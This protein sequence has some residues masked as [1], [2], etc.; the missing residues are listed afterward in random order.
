MGKVI[1]Q[2]SMSLDGFITG[3]NDNVDN[4]M[5]EG[6]E[7]LHD[8]MFDKSTSA[9]QK[10]INEW[11]KNTGAV[12]MGRHSFDVGVGPWDDNPPFHAS[13]FVLS[14]NAQEKLVKKGGTTC[15]F[16][17][18]GIKSALE[19]AKKAAGDKQVILHGAN[20]F[21]QYLSAGLVDELH[22]H[23]IPV[24]LGEGKRLF[25]QIDRKHIELERLK[26][27][28]TPEATHLTFRVLK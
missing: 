17:T 7:R 4:S 26:V 22:I 5:G 28:E 6:G 16:V 27:I 25:D 19:K 15:F 2:M 18:D 10:I 21:Q 14:H 20:I 12:I 3:P 8:W 24:L 11:H 23:L 13:V 1:L 9:D